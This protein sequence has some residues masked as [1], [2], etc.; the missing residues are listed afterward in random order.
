M[1]T[2]CAFSYAKA[3]Y[4]CDSEFTQAVLTRV[5][6][7]SVTATMKAEN[8]AGVQMPVF[9]MNHDPTKDSETD[10]L[11]IGCGGQV[12]L[13]REGARHEEREAR[14]GA[15]KFVSKNCFPGDRHMPRPASS[16]AYATH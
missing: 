10:S 1:I 14:Q 12:G 8:C 5:K 15:R 16:R 7:P 13:M 11:G 6:R 9:T 4:A 2:D 3:E